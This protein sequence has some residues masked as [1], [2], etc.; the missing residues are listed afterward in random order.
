MNDRASSSAEGRGLPLTD[1]RV[2]DLTHVLAGPFCT[3]QLAVLGADVIKIEGPQTPDMMRAEGPDDQLAQAGMGIHFQSQSAG[4]RSLVLDLK[5]PEGQ[6]IL[7]ALIV[8]ADVLVA[9]Y[10]PTAL[11]GLGLDYER[12]NS[13]NGRLVFCSITGFGQSG[14]KRDDPAY[15]NVIQAFSGLMAATGSV[16]SGP[17]KVGPPVLDYGTGAQA[18]LAIMASLYQRTRTGCGDCID[19]AMLDSALMLM[20]AT[21][22]DTSAS[23]VAPQ[24]TG[25]SSLVRAG[26]GCYATADGDL[27]I[28]A[29]TARQNARLW[30]ALGVADRGAQRE[31]ASAAELRSET[32]SD[33]KLLASLLLENTAGHWE[34]L[35]NKAGVPAARVRTL[36]ETL[37]HPQVASRQVIQNATG[38]TSP[39]P[40]LQVPV[41]AWSANEVKPSATGSPPAMGQHT[42]EILLDLGLDEETLTDLQTSGIVG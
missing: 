36:N 17:V 5:A 13:L 19:V 21:V 16:Q 26:Y 22:T 41:A 9:N 37:E 10:T 30:Q 2:L 40:G 6:E 24:R 14:P 38:V 23:G 25:N 39:G 29:F 15:D 35:L 18:A 27:M 11:S 1:I 33:R 28:G 32:D 31:N 34:E 42:K 7:E 8:S 20:T 3:Y 4:K 12:L